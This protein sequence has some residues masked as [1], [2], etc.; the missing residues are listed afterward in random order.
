VSALKKGD[1][2]V[3]KRFNGVKSTARYLSVDRT[4]KRG[5]W[6]TVKPDKQDDPIKIRQGQIIKINGQAV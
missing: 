4:G 2:L 1:E 5:A 6:L 3:F